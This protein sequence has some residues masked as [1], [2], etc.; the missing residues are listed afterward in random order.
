MVFKQIILFILKV[1]VRLKALVQVLPQTQWILS[2]D[3]S[4]DAEEIMSSN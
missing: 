1:M 4:V 3:M 2:L